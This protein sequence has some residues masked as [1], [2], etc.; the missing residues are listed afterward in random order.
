MESVNITASGR[1]AM[2][3]K[4]TKAIRREGLVPCVLY[5][6][7]E[8]KHF[9][10]P[11]KAFKPLIFS[12]D[13]KVAE[14]SIDGTS[15]KCIL[16]A[17][18]F[19]PV[20]DHLMHLDFI[21]L[22]PGQSVNAEVPVKCVGVSPG[23]KTGGKLVQKIRRVKIKTTPENLVDSLSVDISALELGFSVRVSDIITP[24]GIVIANAPA[25]PVAS[26]ETPRALKSA[27]TAEAKEEAAGGGEEGAEA[28]A[29]EA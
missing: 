19:H 27:A 11:E 7:A 21:E 14:I 12:P 29:P 17:S 5:G 24:E 9:A 20:G 18:Q 10:A 4:P 1:S 16:K 26:V 8:V 23:V 13:F 22:I 25:I 3:K 2:G 15:H 28:A 6:G